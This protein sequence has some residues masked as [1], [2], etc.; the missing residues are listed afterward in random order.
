[1]ASAGELKLVPP[2]NCSLCPRLV[3]Y[4]QQ[5]CETIPHGHNRP[6]LDFGNNDG[7]M[8]IVGLAPGVMG[9]NRTGRPFTGDYAGKVLYPALIA[10]GFAKGEFAER[11][12]DGLQLT[13]ALIANCVRCVP[14]E[15]KPTAEEVN[16]CR[17][18]LAATIAA[19]PR[20]RVVLTLGMIAHKS[21]LRHFRLRVADYPFVHGATYPIA[22]H[23][24]SLVS[25][26]HCSQ[27][28]IFTKRLTLDQFH[29]VINQ[30]RQLIDAP[31]R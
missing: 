19:M 12:D 17:P 18:F 1:M 5:N 24:F 9:A 16:N 28:N 13:D 22:A 14:P 20:L 10:H 3:A 27:Y 29:S 4:R 30:C 23:G 7:R 2:P 6:V 11:A 8:L 25:S 15:N 31:L 21:L 26:Y